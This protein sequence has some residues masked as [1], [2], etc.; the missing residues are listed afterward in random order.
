MSSDVVIAITPL[1][2]A[3]SEGRDAILVSLAKYAGRRPD[4]QIGNDV[5]Q[6]LSTNSLHPQHKSFQLWTSPSA[7]KTFA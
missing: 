4:E 6:F 5:R 3:L 1:V 2:A 7:N